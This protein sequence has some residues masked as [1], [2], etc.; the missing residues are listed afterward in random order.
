MKLQ[1]ILTVATI[2]LIFLVILANNSFAT[3]ATV[4]TDTLKLRKEASTNSDVLE[5]LNNGQK[6]D[7][8][9]KSGDWYKVTINN[10]TGFVHKDYIKLDDEL[11]GNNELNTQTNAT[12]NTVE[13]EVINSEEPTTNNIDNNQNTTAEYEIKEMKLFSDSNGYILPLINSNII[14]ELKKDMNVTVINEAGNWR[15][16]QTEEVNCWIRKENLSEIANQTD[17]TNTGTNTNQNTN[18]TIKE[19]DIE[20]KTLYVNTASIYVRKGPGTTYEVV[21]SLI[22]NNTVTVIAE[23]GDWYKVTI[24]GKEGYIAKRLLSAT[25][26]ETTSRGDVERTQT[27]VA[28]ENVIPDTSTTS[29][30]EQIVQY[31]KQYLECPYSYGASGP[32]K[33]DCSGFTMYVFKNFGINLSHSATAQSKN[34]IYV[35]KENLQPG[36]LV[37]FKDYETMNGIGHCGIYVENGN[38]IHASSGT[39]YCVKIST[40][41]SGSYYNRY[42][43]AKRLI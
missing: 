32:S 37:F 24:D 25:K 11:T 5:L 12:T 10:M 33:F 38:F 3:T 41:L 7:V 29:K 1:K 34:G 36:D 9:E 40:L 43:T 19:T 39:G 21:D 6:L 4:N 26:Q 20:D 27:E 16:I 23:S 8:I 18:N 35:A 30:G 14:V 2:L 42:E 15:Y 31:A 13:N 22:L 17:N 28:K